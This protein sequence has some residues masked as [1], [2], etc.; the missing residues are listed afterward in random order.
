MR[1]GA[2]ARTRMPRYQTTLAALAELHGNLFHSEDLEV[3]PM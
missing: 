3:A 1:P 2:I